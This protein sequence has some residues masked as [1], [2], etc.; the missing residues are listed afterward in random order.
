MV[1]YSV[2]S[3]EV[4]ATP[5]VMVEV[6]AMVYYNA[7]RLA[8]DSPLLR[9]ICTQILADEAAHIR[10]QCER[11]AILH[12]ARSPWLR[13][14]TM[15]AHRLF[16]TAITLAVW[17]G[18]RRALRAGG[19]RFCRFWRAARHKMGHAWRMMATQ[20]YFWDEAHVAL[21]QI[22]PHAK[23][24]NGD[25]PRFKWSVQSQWREGNGRI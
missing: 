20:S 8:T 7:I 23:L 3:M 6:H 17:I 13:A 18:H 14:L 2:P 11:L 22:F 19:Y 9:Q 21:V 25:C 15:A 16:F 12:R 4:W 24:E 5:V 1:R 10:F